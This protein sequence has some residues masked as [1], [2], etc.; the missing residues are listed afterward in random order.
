MKK[1][2]FKAG[3]FP[4]QDQETREALSGGEVVPQLKEK[5]ERV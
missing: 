4:I 2:A 5:V 3:V 1:I